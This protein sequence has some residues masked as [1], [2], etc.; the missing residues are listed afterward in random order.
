MWNLCFFSIIAWHSCLLSISP[1]ISGLPNICKL[2]SCS[3]FVLLISSVADIPTFFHISASFF[4]TCSE[5][6]WG[7]W[8]LIV[9]SVVQKTGLYGSNGWKDATFLM[10]EKP[11]GETGVCRVSIICTI[12]CSNL[13][14]V[15]NHA[16]FWVFESMQTILWSILWPVYNIHVS[17]T[18]VLIVYD[19]HATIHHHIWLSSYFLFFLWWSTRVY[20][21]EIFA[22]CINEHRQKNL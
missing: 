19:I 9:L 10:Y 4:S 2:K 16:R 7:L 13:W 20:W 21:H 3:H 14:F 22:W 18:V 11:E 6:L 15:W 8:F 12:L 1:Y 17:H 5:F